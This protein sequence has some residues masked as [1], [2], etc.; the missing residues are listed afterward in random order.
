MGSFH[1]KSLHWSCFGW[2]A[3]K[4]SKTIWWGS[5]E[6]LTH[7]SSNHDEFSVL[8]WSSCQ[9][10][11]CKQKKKKTM[12]FRREK[13]WH[14]SCLSCHVSLL[15]MLLE[16]DYK[17]DNALPLRPL[18][19]SSLTFFFTWVFLYLSMV[20]FYKKRQD[21]KNSTSS[22]ITRTNSLMNWDAYY[23]SKKFNPLKYHFY[24]LLKF[25]AIEFENT[26]ENKSFEEFRATRSSNYH[27]LQ[28]IN[29]PLDD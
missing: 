2:I 15:F 25:W 24:S 23:W 26:V 18:L 7:P 13:F 9:W 11:L 5:R 4:I 17:S 3:I 12:R 14:A 22:H 28:Q 8:C 19:K 10:R 6:F 20:A 21:L 29:N 27:Q 16:I 1:L